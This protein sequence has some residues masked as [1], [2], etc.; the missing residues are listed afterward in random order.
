MPLIVFDLGVVRRVTIHDLDKIVEIERKCFEKDIAYTRD[1]LKYLITRAK[2][3][4]FA[5]ATEDTLRGF[6][7]LVHRQGTDVAGIETLNVDPAFHGQGIG[8]KLL[9]VAEQNILQQGI[10]KIRL[11]VSMGNHP[12]IRLYEKS[13][14]RIIEIL[15]DFYNYE[16]R[17][18]KDA[19]RMIKDLTT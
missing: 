2:S 14:F 5:E 17:G 18:T 8:R 15:K 11:E 1:Q 7:I 4:C 19:Y 12:A 9:T 3:N 16:H 10:K 6:I 13:G